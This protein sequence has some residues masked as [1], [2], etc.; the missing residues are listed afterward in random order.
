MD[1]METK[2]SW[3]YSYFDN[4]IRKFNINN[5]ADNYTTKYTNKIKA[6]VS[7]RDRIKFNEAEFKAGTPE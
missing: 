3:I 5:R 2:Y 4:V 7:Y 1:F 6:K